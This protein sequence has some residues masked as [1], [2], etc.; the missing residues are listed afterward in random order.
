MPLVN[1]EIVELK[2]EEDVVATVAK[3]EE[4]VSLSWIIYWVKSEPP[5]EVGA[6]QDRKTCWLP[7]VA[8]KDCGGEGAVGLFEHETETLEIL[9]EA[10]VPL[11]L[12]TPQV[13]PDGCV[14]TVTLYVPPVLVAAAKV[15]EPLVEVLMLSPPIPPLFS[16]TTVP[17]RPLMVPPTV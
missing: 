1:P 8:L 16:N 11:P 10:T 7:G 15:K 14:K 4:A 2:V 17:A 3:V 12:L 13:W 6:D 5:V 9:L